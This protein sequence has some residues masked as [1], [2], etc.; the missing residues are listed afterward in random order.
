MLFSCS[1]NFKNKFLLNIV[2]KYYLEIAFSHQHSKEIYM[3]TLYCLHFLR[4]FFEVATYYETIYRLPTHRR[5]AKL[6]NF[7]YYPFS[8]FNLIL[9]IRTYLP[10]LVSKGLNILNIIC[11]SSFFFPQHL[12]TTIIVQKQNRGK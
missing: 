7:F 4:R 3:L 12:F 6:L 5:V 1:L 8:F 11:L 10:T 9:A 2:T